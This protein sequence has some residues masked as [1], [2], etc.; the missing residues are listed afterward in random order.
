MKSEIRKFNYQ[1]EGEPIEEREVFVMAETD[2]AIAGYDRNRVTLDDKETLDDAK[3]AR[4]Q[5]VFK[6]HEIKD[7]MPTR[8]KKVDPATLTEEER[9]IKSFLVGWRQFRKDRM[10]D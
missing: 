6:N 8:G 7:V 1:K 9:E 2:T 3:W 10:V 4:I 5:E